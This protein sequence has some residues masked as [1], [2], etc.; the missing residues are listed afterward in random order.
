MMVGRLTP[1]ATMS[2]IY[3]DMKI[4]VEREEKHQQ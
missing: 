4:S 2:G 3:I 1:L